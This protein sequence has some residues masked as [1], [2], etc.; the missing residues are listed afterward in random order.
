MFKSLFATEYENPF[1]FMYGIVF[2]HKNDQCAGY[3]NSCLED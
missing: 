1:G 3:A 2:R